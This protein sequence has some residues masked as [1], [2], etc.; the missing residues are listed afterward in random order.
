MQWRTMGACVTAAITVIGCPSS[1]RCAPGERYN[2]QYGICAG[3]CTNPDD[4]Q[5]WGRDGGFVARRD[6]ASEAS[7]GDG[8]DGDA[9]MEGGVVIDPAIRAPRPVFPCSLCDTTSRRPTFRWALPAGVEGAVLELCEDRPCTRV[10][11]RVRADGAQA[12]PRAELPARRPVFWRLRGRSGAREGSETSPTWLLHTP[13][14][15]APIS[16]AGLPH[17]DVNGDGLDDVVVGAPPGVLV[18]HGRV[19]GLARQPDTTLEESVSGSDYGNVLD[20]ADVDGDGFGDLVVGA[21]L[22]S[23][24]YLYRGSSRGI[25]SESRQVIA[26]AEAESAFGTSIAASDFDGDGFADVVIAGFPRTVEGGTT[27]WAYRGGVWDRARDWRAEQRVRLNNNTATNRFV[28]FDV[29]DVD[30]DARADLA[31]QGDTTRAEFCWGSSDTVISERVLLEIGVSDIGYAAGDINGDGLFDVLFDGTKLCA[32]RGDRR[33][34]VSATLVLPAAIATSNVSVTGGRDI[35]GD[36]V[37]D[38]VVAGNS[39]PTTTQI[40]V[41]FGGSRTQ[42]YTHALTLTDVRVTAVAGDVNG[43]G[44]ADLVVGQSDATTIRFGYEPGLPANPD[45]RQS[46]TA[47]SVAQ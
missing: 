34:E 40:A 26:Q 33:F 30:G 20:V 9:T 21:W 13:A 5:C 6:G 10:I 35:N 38:V 18:F 43:D 47:R 7:T 17:V 4:V 31:A 39:S 19:S 32:G 12:T 24:V 22:G 23:R 37:A 11:E 2:E 44:R 15:S 29:G 45:W 28:L 42:T 16:T 3:D 1:E 27:L 8:G 46:S 41:W 25:E 14:R 36:G